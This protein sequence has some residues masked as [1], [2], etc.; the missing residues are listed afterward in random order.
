ML[1]SLSVTGSIYTTNN[2]S[3]VDKNGTFKQMLQLLWALNNDEARIYAK[4]PASD[5]IDFV[6][7]L[8]DNNSVD[9]YVYWIDDY[10]GGSHDRYPLNMH[11]GNVL[12][13]MTETSEGYPTLGRPK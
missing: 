1:G 13:H 6:F 7:K 4:Q 5:Q 2:I 9:R 8:S 3:F 11:G 12:F 10:R